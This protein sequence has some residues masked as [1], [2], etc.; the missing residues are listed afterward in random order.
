MAIKQADPKVIPFANNLL[1][2]LPKSYLGNL[3]LLPLEQRAAID[4]DARRWRVANTM[5]EKRIAA[6][7]LAQITK[8]NRDIV[9]GLST[10]E[11]SGY[12]EDMR[13]RLNILKGKLK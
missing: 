8:A 6:A 10:M 4:E 2:S 9:D 13:R 3:A 5:F 7:G 12:R 1:E 11:P